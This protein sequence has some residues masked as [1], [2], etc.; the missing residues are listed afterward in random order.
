MSSAV[1]TTTQATK[2]KPTT[3]TKVCGRTTTT[4]LASSKKQTNAN[5]QQQWQYYDTLGRTTR[6][7]DDA[8]GSNTQTTC[9]HYDSQFKGKLDSTNL[10]QGNSCSGTL[11]Q[12][13]TQTYDSLARPTISQ[14]SNATQKPGDTTRNHYT[15]TYYDGL[16]RVAVQQLNQDFAVVN[17]FNNRGFAYKQ[18]RADD[19]TTLKEIKSTTTE[20][21]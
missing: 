12:S 18:T 20:A 16:G 14:T 7:I 3:R 21:R 9:W 15:R 2:P 13:Q 11:I 1:N 19:G 10:Y 17:H 5:G 8:L 6:R 4:P